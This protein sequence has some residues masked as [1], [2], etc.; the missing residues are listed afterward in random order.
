MD[1]EERRI[2][3]NQLAAKYDQV[4]AQGYKVAQSAGINR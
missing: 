1:P 2:K 3:I 4:A